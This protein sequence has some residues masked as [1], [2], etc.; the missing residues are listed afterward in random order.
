MYIK[1]IACEWM[2]VCVRE[3]VGVFSLSLCL[4]LCRCGSIFNVLFNDVSIRWPWTIHREME[5]N[6][7]FYIGTC[8]RA[9]GL[10]A[11]KPT[12][13]K[14]VARLRNLFHFSLILCLHSTVKLNENFQPQNYNC[15]S[16]LVRSQDALLRLPIII[17]SVAVSCYY[18]NV[19]DY[20]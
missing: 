17:I 19:F 4:S 14:V 15:T 3:N 11:L 7:Y 1:K 10:S 20:N 8:F 18:Y 13:L 5:E 12:E 2:S 6:K 9:S 16:P